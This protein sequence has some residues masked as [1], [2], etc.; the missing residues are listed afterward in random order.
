[1]LGIQPVLH[2]DLKAPG[3][4]ALSHAAPLSSLDTSCKQPLLRRLWTPARFL[5][6]RRHDA[7]VML[8]CAIRH[9][10]AIRAT[11]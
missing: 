5:A 2:L 9:K 4:P 1:M 11:H 3:N 6:A 10:V 8:Q 7:C